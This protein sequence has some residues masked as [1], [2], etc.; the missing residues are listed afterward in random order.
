MHQLMSQY[1]QASECDRPRV[2]G[3]TGML[4]SG[5]VKS[6]TVTVNLDKLEATLHATIATVESYEEHQNVQSFS[7][8]PDEKIVKYET[9][10]RTEF[11][12]RIESIVLKITE[13]AKC[14]PGVGSL[15]SKIKKM[16][17]DFR[18]QQS[19]LGE[20]IELV[21]I[22]RHEFIILV[23]GSYGASIAILSVL[24]ELE[25]LKNSSDTKSTKQLIRQCI[26]CKFNFFYVGS[27]KF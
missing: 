6:H 16:M 23:L 1:A 4:L 22:G 13:K 2:I 10:S 9:K 21:N 18:Y 26:A 15:G 3:L 8:N 12:E 7:T 25:L 19:E 20:N 24:V 5:S 14:W 17:D 11:E 27:Q